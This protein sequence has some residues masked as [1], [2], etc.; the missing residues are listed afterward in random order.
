[1]HKL[2]LC[3]R[4]LRKRRMAFFGIAAVSLCVA[5]LIVI[6]SLFN[7]FIRSFNGFWR[8]TYGDIVLIPNH[9]LNSYR[10]LVKHLERVEGVSRARALTST[11]ALLYLGRGD[12][13][14]V[15]IIGADLDL[16]ARDAIFKEKLLRQN[17]SS[18]APSFAL[19]ESA[20]RQYRQWYTKK[21]RRPPAADDLPVG[22]IVG[23][24]VLAQP[25]ELTDQYNHPAV[26]E[27]IKQQDSPWF[28][29]TSNLGSAADS[30]KTSLKKIRKTCWPVDV[31]Q[32]GI[33]HADTKNVYLPFEYLR[34]TIGIESPE[35]KKQCLAR[36][37]IYLQP[38]CDP[39]RY[40]DSIGS[41]WIAFA[42]ENLHWPDN[43]IG[44]TLLY[45]TRNIS[46]LKL[47]IGVI[48]KQLKIMQ[49]ILGLICLVATLLIFVILFMIVM[50]KK[51]D[52]GILRAVG[53][54]RRAVGILFIGYGTTIGVVGSLLGLVL[55]IWAT[56][57]INLIEALLVKLLGFKI[58]KSGVYLFSEIPN[59][60]D[61]DALGWIILAGIVTALLGALLP[62][63]RAARLQPVE[64]LRY[65]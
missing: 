26:I 21:F 64:A 6:T 27:Q 43:W 53:S 60:V 45:P 16:L 49:L 8:Q 40:R 30:P 13:R 1:M 10:P 5:L 59:E 28:I 61:T 35:G 33:H 50:Q 56:H 38:G 48:N 42:R 14:A 34:D 44:G 22:C 52:I 31:I 20:V 55:G 2:F 12:V 63:L 29:T 9:P 58:W 47:I 39:D 54:S 4:Y 65:E 11:G 57:N 46:N 7:G 3:L 15:E 19:P 62:A 23:I 24:G 25:D 18:Y 37:Q 32:T 36:I 51:K 41:A 17:D